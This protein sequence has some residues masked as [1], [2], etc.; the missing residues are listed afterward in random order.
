MNIKFLLSALLPFLVLHMQAKNQEV[1]YKSHTIF[2]DI[3]Q[4]GLPPDWS[5]NSD[6][7]RF[8]VDSLPTG[9]GKALKICG[10]R[11]SIAPSVLTLTTLPVNRENG[12]TFSM[13][14]KTQSAND[15]LLMAVSAMD[16]MA[17]QW[18]KG[19][20]DWKDY[21][22]SIPL[23]SN[24]QIMIPQLMFPDAGPYW[25]SETTVEM[26]QESYPAEEDHEFD[27]GSAIHAIP[28][29]KNSIDKLV[30]LGKI[31]GFLK[32]YHPMVCDG[33]YNWDYELFRWLPEVLKSRSKKEVC[34]LV[35]DKVRS[36]G[37]LDKGNHIKTDF[38]ACDSLFYSIPSFPW[39]NEIAHFH[40]PLYDLLDSIKH[41]DRSQTIHYYNKGLNS[42]NSFPTEAKYGEKLYPDAGFRLLALYRYWN[43]IEYFYPY[44]KDI[45]DKSWNRV[46][47]RFIPL[48]VHAE[49]AEEYRST[50]DYLG[51]CLKDNH[52]SRQYSDS[53][54][55]AEERN[56]Y[57]PVFWD[58][59]ERK[60]TVTD[61]FEGQ[62]SLKKGDVVCQINGVEVDDLVKR[63]ARIISASNERSL[64]YA[65]SLD[66]IQQQDSVTDLNI[67]W[68]HKT[69]K[70]SISGLT[71]KEYFPR[72][73]KSFSDAPY[74]KW[75]SDSIGYFSP[76]GQYRSDSLPL[77]MEKFKDAKAIVIDMRNYPCDLLHHMA[78]YLLPHRVGCTRTTSVVPDFPGVVRWNDIQYFGKENPDCYSGKVVVLINE[79]T[80]SMG[81]SIV[82]ILRHCPNAILVG[83]PTAGSDGPISIFVLPGAV[84]VRFTG[85]GFYFANKEGI[86]NRGISPDVN[87]DVTPKG[88]ASDT[89]ELL[90]KALDIIE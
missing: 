38:P 14:V 43:I 29:D 19:S 64:L 83:S 50:I 78:D 24:S 26:T 62:T 58:F 44:R 4:P 25:I 2:S 18:I 16:T 28:T 21:T 84:H 69:L 1:T 68:D 22:V 7:H 33:Q 45:T 51:T 74:Y 47:T 76:I 59:V 75:L 3:S 60:L 35:F 23:S 77:V 85:E 72:K 55:P 87:V 89:D 15:S 17:M 39:M 30:L 27:A 80:V 82:A 88:V 37:P 46:L 9:E 34:E 70:V 12:V 79:K 40:K 32:Y 66:L 63:Y 67:K 6:S 5:V 41:A 56:Y 11:D 65:V 71:P 42:M 90:L 54:L 61:D 8:T 86:Q 73:A 57:L 52:T 81:E 20:T 10:A 36:M 31:W 48:F 49:N 53:I 13:R